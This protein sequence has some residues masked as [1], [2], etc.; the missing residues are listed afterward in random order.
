M[1]NHLVLAALPAAL[2]VFMGSSSS[3]LAEQY[4]GPVVDSKVSIVSTHP[5]KEQVFTQ[6]LEFVTK[7]SLLVSS[8][9]YGQS[10]IRRVNFPNG[11]TTASEGLRPDQFGEGATVIG[12]EVHQ[13]TWKNHL[14]N[15]YSKHNMKL[16]RTYPVTGDGWGLCYDKSTGN[17]GQLIKSDGSNALTTYTTKWDKTGRVVLPSMYQELNELECVVGKDNKP[18]VWANQW[19]KNTILL[20][21]LKSGTVEREVDLSKVVEAEGSLTDEQVLNGIAAVPGS[22]DLLVTGK[23]WR[24]MYRINVAGLERNYSSDSNQT[25]TTSATIATFENQDNSIADYPWLVVL[26]II[27]VLAALFGVW[28]FIIRNIQMQ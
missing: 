5:L 8:G 4:S 18:K 28:F 2:L 19:H 7:D 14:V 11:E 20:I 16:E 12:D 22:D 1:K 15:V 9:L 24:N 3:A 23:E 17:G 25:Q 10:S 21:D 26:H 6:G 13:L 27:L